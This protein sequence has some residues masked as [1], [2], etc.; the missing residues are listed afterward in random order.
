M[1]DLVPA[2]DIE[3][4]VGAPRHPTLHI[5]RAVSAEERVYILHSQACKDSTPDLRTCRYS[6]DL[7]DCPHAGEWPEDQPLALGYI[8]GGLIGLPMAYVVGL[9]ERQRL[10]P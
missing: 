3:R 10:A 7:D 1:T 2:E 5:A 6:R 9:L 4:I 8:F